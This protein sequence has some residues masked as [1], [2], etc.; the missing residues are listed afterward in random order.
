MHVLSHIIRGFS[1]RWLVLYNPDDSPN[2][3][4]APG[5]VLNIGLH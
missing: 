1:L 5:Y 2:I 4:Q 3:C